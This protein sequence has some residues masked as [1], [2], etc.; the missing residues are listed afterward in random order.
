LTSGE[1][2]FII[3]NK[4][5]CLYLRWGYEEMTNVY[6]TECNESI[7]NLIYIIETGVKHFHPTKIGYCKVK[8][9]HWWSLKK[10]VPYTIINAE[11][12]DLEEQLEAIEAIGKI[13]SIQ[14]LDFLLKLWVNDGTLHGKSYPYGGGSGASFIDYYLRHP[15]F[16]NA[17]G[18]KLGDR[19]GEDMYKYRRSQLTNDKYVINYWEDLFDGLF[20]EAEQ[21]LNRLKDETQLF[22]VKQIHSELMQMGHGDRAKAYQLYF[23]FYEM[24]DLRTKKMLN[25]E[26]NTYLILD[27][28]LRNVAW[29]L[30]KTK[31][32]SIIAKFIDLVEGN[33]KFS[34]PPEANFQEVYYNLD[35]QLFGIE[36]LRETRSTIVLNYLQ[37]LAETKIV[38]TRSNKTQLVFPNAK[39]KLNKALIDGY[40]KI[41]L[42]R[43]N[44]D[45]EG[46]LLDNAY[47]ILMLAIRKMKETT[48]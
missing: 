9:P 33:V 35:Y 23:E 39:Y 21:K 12:Y 25:K 36:A 28:A 32:D 3:Q 45:M 13:K 42:F 37:K 5:Y 4:F 30:A 44:N 40:N 18:Q 7:D 27:T 31:D 46:I 14:A 34:Y 26:R 19:L 17:K 11:H 29:Q 6:N 48:A 16:P 43:H 22:R 38:E 41:L 2:K 1:I 10:E 47:V 8:G 20:D 24:L 15:N